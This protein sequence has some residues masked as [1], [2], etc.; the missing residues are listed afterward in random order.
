MWQILRGRRFAGFKFRRQVPFQNFILDFVCFEKGLVIEV[1]GSQHANSS[2]DEAR[3]ALLASEG[4]ETLR[5]WNNAVLGS[6]RLIQEDIWN[7]LKDFERNPSP[8]GGRGGGPPTTPHGGGEGNPPPLRPPAGLPTAHLPP[9]AVAPPPPPG[10][11][12]GLGS[13]GPGG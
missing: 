11:W 7:R 6:P 4:F 12:G 9:P 5:Y 1:D 13:G 8:G 3:D 2:R 10:G